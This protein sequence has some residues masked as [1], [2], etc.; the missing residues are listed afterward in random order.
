MGI[1]RTLPVHVR[2]VETVGA[3]CKAPPILICGV[4]VV[5]RLGGAVR[6]LP[7]VTK[8]ERRKKPAL[9]TGSQL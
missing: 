1:L 7:K 6:W 4:F 2:V 5:L 8:D 3:L 9:Q